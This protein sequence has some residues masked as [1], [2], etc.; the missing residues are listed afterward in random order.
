VAAVAQ[1]R[2]IPSGR[3][4]DYA[5]VIPVALYADDWRNSE[6]GVLIKRYA[7]QAFDNLIVN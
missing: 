4:G 5:S 2:Y 6:L 1:G 3:L 7:P